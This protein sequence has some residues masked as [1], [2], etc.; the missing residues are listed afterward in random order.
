SSAT[1]DEAVT[2]LAGEPGLQLT[3]ASAAQ[4]TSLAAPEPAAAS[5]IAPEPDVAFHA[6]PEPDAP[7]ARP[8]AAQEDIEARIRTLYATALEYPEEVFEP[9]AEL[10][11]DL[12]VDSVK[13]AELMARLG[14][15]FALGPRPEG[16]RIGDY[17]TF[18]QLVEFVSDALPVNGSRR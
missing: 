16:L 5:V 6:A 1:L 2:F 8:P 11:A 12:G 14:E 17:R 18:G 13:Q 3:A 9:A 15:E 7:S 10:E 4:A